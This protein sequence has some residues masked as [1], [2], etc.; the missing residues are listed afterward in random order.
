MYSRVY[1]LT[2]CRNPSYVATGTV[3]YM[4]VGSTYIH[5]VKE[6]SLDLDLHVDLICVVGFWLVGSGRR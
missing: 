3:D 2:T 1:Y 6:S 5:H 4:Y